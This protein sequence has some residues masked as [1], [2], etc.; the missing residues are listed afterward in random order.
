MIGGDPDSPTESCIIDTD[1]DLVECKRHGQVLS[2]GYTFYPEVFLVEL[3]YCSNWYMRLRVNKL[4]IKRVLFHI[5]SI[6]FISDVSVI[7]KRIWTFRIRWLFNDHV[8][9]IILSLHRRCMKALI[10]DFLNVNEITI[11]CWT[12]GVSAVI[13][14][15]SWRRWWNFCLKR[16]IRSTLSEKFS[17]NR[18]APESV[19]QVGEI[20][21]RAPIKWAYPFSLLNRAP[22]RTMRRQI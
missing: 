21:V 3:D 11:L 7:M 10:L 4:C 12:V 22:S 8:T 1:Y 5:K 13:I 20:W 14:N 19:R 9:M 6:S 16:T 18:E 2:P 15:Y 17:I